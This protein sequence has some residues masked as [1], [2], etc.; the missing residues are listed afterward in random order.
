M[1]SSPLMKPVHCLPFFKDKADYTAYKE[2]TPD[3][4]PKFKFRSAMTE[5]FKNNLMAEIAPLLD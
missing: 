3:A 1:S 2:A 4:M 5:D